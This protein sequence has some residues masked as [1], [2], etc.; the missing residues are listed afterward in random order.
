[1]NKIQ[2]IGRL[3]ANPELR[4]TSSG[5]SVCGFTVAVNRRFDKEEADFFP[6][7]VWRDMA[8]NCNKYLAKGSQVGVCGS[9]QIRRYEDSEGIK[10]IAVDL[11]ADEVE[12]LSSRNDVQ[13]A[14]AKGEQTANVD[15]TELEEVDDED[16][17]F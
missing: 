8:V 4:T 2:I 1:M 5:I 13:T 3:T 17:P 7:T 9:L 15:P 12:F 10:R 11:Q 14:P 16:M 6:V